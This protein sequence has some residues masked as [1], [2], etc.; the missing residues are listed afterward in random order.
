VAESQYAK[1]TSSSSSSTVAKGIAWQRPFHD[2]LYAAPAA[3]QD[4]SEPEVQAKEERSPRSAFDL[5]SLRFGTPT[6]AYAAPLGQQSLQRQESEEE[7]EEVQPQRIQTKLTVGQ[8]GDRY[9][10]EADA[11]AARVMTMPEPTV[12]P[13][14]RQEVETEE[15]PIQAKAIQR[16]E[17]LEEDEPVQARMIQREELP[18]EEPLQARMIQRDELPEE[19]ELIQARMIQREEMLEEEEPVQMKRI[20]RQEMAEEEEPIQAR[21]IQREELLE[22][23]EPVQARMIQREE[24]PEEEEEPVQ[25]KRIQRQ[26]MAEEEEPIQAKSI[27]TLQRRVE[28]KPIQMKAIAA[29]TPTASLESQLHGSK[30][31]GSPLGDETR[32]FMESRFNTDFSHVRVHTGSSAVQMN[33]DLQAQ[34]F[35]HG[36]D[37][38]YG[39]GK[40]PGQNDLTAHELT[41][42]IQQ[43]GGSQLQAKQNKSGDKLPQIQQKCEACEAKED[44]QRKGITNKIVS[45]QRKPKLDGESSPKIQRSSVEYD[46]EKTIQRQP[47]LGNKISYTENKGMVQAFSFGDTVNSRAKW[48]GDKASAGAQWVGD[49]ASAGAQWVGDKASAGAQWVGDKAVQVAS[50]SKEQFAELVNKVAPGLANLI[51][52]GPIGIL[53]D[54]IKDGLK[55]WLSSVISGV[56][57]G[58]VISTLQGSFAEVFAGVQALGKGDPASCDA[59]ADSI[60]KLRDL[61]HAFMNNPAIKQV[62]TII[63]KVTDV[64]RKV[65]S[66]LVAPVFD[67]LMNVAGGVFSAVQ[68]F[69]NT[70]WEWGAPVRSTVGAAWDW[71]KQQLGMDGDGSGGVFNWLKTKASEV[72][73]QLKPMFA[74]VIEPLKKVGSTLLAFSPVGQFAAIAK[75][76]PKLTQMAGWLWANKGDKELVKRA[77]QEMGHTVLPQLLGAV[78]G[79]S[80]TIQSTVSGLVGQVT[81]ITESVMGLL[82]AISGVPLLSVARSLAQQLSETLKSMG[83]WAKETFQSTARSVQEA[84]VKI[85]AKIQPYAGVLSSLGLAIVN[86]AMIPAIFAGSAWRAL[87]DCYKAPIIDFLLDAV[88]GIL[89]AAPSLPTFGVLWPML[90]TGV[91]GFLQGLKAQSPEVKVAV[92]N[93]LAKII[94][95]G[96][97]AFLLGFAK[98]LLKGIWEGL[99]DPFV[100]MYDALKGLGNLTVWLN[101]AASAALAPETAR[102]SSESPGSDAAVEERGNQSEPD[103]GQRM[104]EMAGEL[105]PPVEEVTQGFMPA[106]REAFSGGEGLTL[107]QLMLKLGEA[108]GAVESAIRG[109][110]TTLA[111]QVCGFLMQDAAEGEM[112]ETTGWLAGTIAFEVALGVLTAGTATAAKGAMKVLQ[113]FAKILDWTGE[114]MGIAFKALAK[115]GG[116][117]L[118]VV[119]G[120]GKLLSK[121]GGAIKAVLDAIAHIAHKLI[122]FADELLGLSKRKGKKATGQELFPQGKASNAPSADRTMH[123]DAPE[124]EPGV[125]A[126]A[127]VADGHQ[128]KVLKDGRLVRC[129]SCEDIRKQNGKL[130]TERPDLGT[131]LSEIEQISDLEEK[132]RKAQAF[133]FELEQIKEA[134]KLTSLPGND[135]IDIAKIPERPISDD[136]YT[137]IRNASNDVEKISELTGLSKEGV[138]QAKQHLMFDKHILVDQDTRELYRGTFTPFSPK[139]DFAIAVWQKI[140]DGETPSLDEISELKRLINHEAGESKILKSDYVSIEILFQRGLLEDHLRQYFRRNGKS[141]D[142]I[143]TILKNEIRPMPPFRYAHYVAHFSGYRN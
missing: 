47:L 109:A 71:V 91:L 5:T 119:K 44:V 133:D 24:L 96:S 3:D 142:Y 98:G 75:F 90:K 127:P 84:V 74:P 128:V 16:E 73:A 83:Q 93:K 94:S 11:M 137:S 65:T 107:E 60:Q 34:A 85:K 12:L 30:G 33:K 50:W 28:N 48:F 18:E 38:Y 59:F 17:M 87:A 139:E 115:L 100:L 79:L 101:D 89:R 7:P 138:T 102:Q 112:G 40:S 77:H 20:Q 120:I 111:N 114:A 31:G 19:E 82:G 70:I 56:N 6:P 51:R 143:N 135:I 72:W 116:Y 132:T 104:R 110:G 69:A 9:E 117:V 27:A 106:L 68:G 123:F 103:M 54:K 43:T 15:E 134:E 129:S 125:V 36:S 124:I 118:D 29:P 76:V 58:N 140:V 21:M 2:P 39:A 1:G 97:P 37:I 62:Q 81:Q 63:G 86:P 35:T 8:P 41:H 64:F 4:V 78:Q 13:V 46:A 32:S 53:T 136:Y 66:G 92:T 113:T 42:V 141:E 67:S 57:I 10:Q 99:T 121:T 14:Q 55:A 108:W 122:A 25:M 22:E 23:E 49:K 131:R 95:G 45:F 61:S 26:E 52:Q 88:I 105:Q 130:F 80:Q 126:K